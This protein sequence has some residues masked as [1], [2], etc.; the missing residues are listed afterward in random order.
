MAKLV[1]FLLH[2]ARSARARVLSQMARAP[3]YGRGTFEAH[4]NYITYMQKVV[5]NPAYAGMPNA[6]SEG[7]RV[8]WQVSS[9]RS[10]SFFK[11][12]R[13]RLSWWEAKADSLGLPHRGQRP[14]N[15]DPVPAA[16]SSAL[17]TSVLPVSAFLA[18]NNATAGG[19]KK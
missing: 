13:A 4:P 7:G 15:S 17:R 16:G 9:G 5:A 12:Y 19:V 11:Y 2:F 18:I 6:V 1:E 14:A 10:T 3:K 8:N